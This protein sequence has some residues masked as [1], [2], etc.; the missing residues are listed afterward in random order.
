[1]TRER[2]ARR[3]REGCGCRPTHAASGSVFFSTVFVFLSPAAASLIRSSLISTLS[4]IV[5]DEE[6]VWG[7]VRSAI[8]WMARVCGR[9]GVDER[10]RRACAL[11]PDDSESVVGETW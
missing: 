10:A 2:G 4:A 1:M 6:V 11:S 5:I 3:T 9:V 7:G 8:G